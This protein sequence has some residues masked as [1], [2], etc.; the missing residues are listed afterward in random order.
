MRHHLRTSSAIGYIS[1]TTRAHL[2]ACTSSGQ[3]KRWLHMPNG[4]PIKLL[5]RPR[6]E[7]AAVQ[8]KLQRGNLE[9]MF[10]GRVNRLKGFGHMV[11]ICSYLDRQLQEDSGGRWLL[12]VVGKET[13]E[14]GELLRSANFRHI[15]LRLY[16]YISDRELNE[17]YRR[18]AACFFLS[19]NE[20]FG[21]PALEACWLGCVPI[22]SDIPIFREVMGADYPL[23][24]LDSRGAAA[25]AGFILDL[26]RQERTR[27][28]TLAALDAVLARHRDGYRE[29]ADNFLSYMRELRPS[30]D[31]EKEMTPQAQACAG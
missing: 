20:G 28:S 5:D 26:Q 9:L 30:L 14:T 8:R 12:H 2:E 29:A 27:T 15:E 25:A 21:L 17:L 31:E 11:E 1:Q 4:L 13:P 23:F 10:V 7:R 24:E 6:P 18:S 16:G 19:K 3:E 22:L